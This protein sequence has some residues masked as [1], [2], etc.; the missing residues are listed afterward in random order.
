MWKQLFICVG[1][2]LLVGCSNTSV[3]ELEPTPLVISLRV[4]LANAT[5]QYGDKYFLKTIERAVKGLPH[6]ASTHGAAFTNEVVINVFYE[7][8][9]KFAEAEDDIEKLMQ[10]LKLPSQLKNVRLAELCGKDLD[11]S[12][13]THI[14]K[15]K[16][17]NIKSMLDEVVDAKPELAANLLPKEEF[18]AMFRNECDEV[19]HALPLY[20]LEE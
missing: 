15:S 9:I 14:A 4:E 5:P 6:V 11:Q 13:L 18:D 17:L 16:G 8:G 12:H 3:P 2:L 10:T 1:V 19:N 20:I 7:E